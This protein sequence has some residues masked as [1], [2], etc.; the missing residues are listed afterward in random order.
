V[1]NKVCDRLPIPADQNG[2]TTLLNPGQKVREISLGF[3]NIDRDHKI[4]LANLAKLSILSR[5]APHT[6][7]SPVFPTIPF[8]LSAFRFPLSAFRFPLSALGAIK[9]GE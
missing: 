9:S 4:N 6:C 5:H 2:F 7:F 8:P 3:M 1:G